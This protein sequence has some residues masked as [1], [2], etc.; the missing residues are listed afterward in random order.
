[1]RSELNR[2]ESNLDG[3]LAA[4]QHDVNQ[5]EDEVTRLTKQP[6]TVTLDEALPHVPELTPKDEDQEH[7][8]ANLGGD[9]YSDDDD[10]FDDDVNTMGDQTNADQTVVQMVDDDGS[11]L[12]AV[13]GQDG[14]LIAVLD[15]D[16][17][18][19]YES[20][21][22]RVANT[23]RKNLMN[24][25]Y[26]VVG[27]VGNVV[28]AG[29]RVA[30]TGLVMAGTGLAKSGERVVQAV[31]SQGV[32]TLQYTYKV[33]T[34][35]GATVVHSAGA[36]VPMVLNRTD[37]TPRDAGF[38][39]FNSLYATQMA[40]QMV[41]HPK[42]YV[43]SVTP[44]PDPADLFWRNVGLPHQAKRSGVLAAVAATT[45]LCFFWSIPMG[46][47]TSLT[48]VQTLKENM[49]KLGDWIDDH[50]WAEPF[51]S[52]LTPLLIFTANEVI[53]PYILKYFATWE[54]HIS[55]A[56]L[57]ASLF[58]KLCCYMVSGKQF[59]LIESLTA[60][61]R[62]FRLSLFLSFLLTV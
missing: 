26:K 50:S 4:I 2:Q 57:E 10:D 24:G 8:R 33:S 11:M 17:E 44:A 43:M 16:E 20:S 35:I 21:P 61:F 23:I 53:L 55:T 25:T 49:P 62:L 52:Q 14:S 60:V 30:G 7:R 28:A 36:V 6:T 56:I 13:V 5:D 48:K 47:I 15:K 27:N 12:Q 39:V 32:E 37:G 19:A 29:S 45:T 58:N 41:H 18:K 42:P 46:F 40:L 34:G 1:M 38:V 3:L 51:F 31:G 54:G 9:I 59:Q 22:V